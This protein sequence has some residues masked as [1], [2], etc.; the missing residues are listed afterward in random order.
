LDE[1]R[2]A[3]CACLGPLLKDM[4]PAYA[5]LIQRIDLEGESPVAVAK[6]LHVTPNNLTVRLHRARRALKAN[7]EQACGICTKHGCLHCTCA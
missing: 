7:L 2:P 5:D 1:V 4:R 6:D 3:L